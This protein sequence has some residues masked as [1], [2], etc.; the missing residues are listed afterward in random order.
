MV[1]RSTDKEVH[2]R[3][4]QKRSRPRH[5]R[6]DAKMTDQEGDRQRRQKYSA[7]RAGLAEEQERQA[8]RYPDESRVAEIAEKS[9]EVIQKRAANLLNRLQNREIN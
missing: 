7:C 3:V 4:H 5:K 9:E 2:A 8:R 6:L 1:G